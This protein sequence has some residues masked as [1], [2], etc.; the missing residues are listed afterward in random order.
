[1]ANKKQETVFTPIK[2]SSDNTGKVEISVDQHEPTDKNH[3]DLGLSED[4]VV[5][6]F[7]Q[8]YLQRRFEERAMQMYQKRKFGGFLHLYIGQEAISTGTVF[9]LDDEDDIITAYRDHGW[10]SEERRVGKGGN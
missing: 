4:D 2:L 6:M 5:V 8:M 7:E 1:M 9:A 3:K 10:R